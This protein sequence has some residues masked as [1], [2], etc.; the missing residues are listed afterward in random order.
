MKGEVLVLEEYHK[1]AARKIVEKIEAEIKGKPERFIITVGGES[2]SGKSETGKAIQD[3]LERHG[4]KAILL[5]QDDY[6][7]LPPKTNNARRRADPDWLGPHKEIRMDVLEK[8]LRD[9]VRGVDEIKKPLI[10]YDKNIIEEET[11]SLKGSKVV[12]AEGTYTS[13]LK[14]VDK[15]IFI[16]R[17]RLDTLEHRM[18][19]KRGD[20]VGDQFVEQILDIEHKIIAGHKHLADIVIT[21]QYDVTFVE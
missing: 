14:T 20:E 11:I 1:Q 3:E 2:G 17:N 19:R 15:R 12:I 16:D 13:M 8:N 4:I 18:K 6:F 10:D 21:K 5:G 9:A 7:V